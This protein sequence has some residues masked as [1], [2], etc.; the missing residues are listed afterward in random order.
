MSKDKKEASAGIVK[1]LWNFFGQKITINCKATIFAG[2]KLL[3]IILCR[4]G[5]KL[6]NG[7]SIAETETP[8]MDIQCGF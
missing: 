1:L 5:A 8:S 2:G 7:L 6:W 3:L 4:K